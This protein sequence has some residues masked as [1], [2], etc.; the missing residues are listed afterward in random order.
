[1]QTS[2]LMFQSRLLD[3]QNLAIMSVEAIVQNCA[4]AIIGL[5]PHEPR[6]L[7]RYS[8]RCLAMLIAAQRLSEQGVAFWRYL[9]PCRTSGTSCVALLIRRAIHHLPLLMTTSLHRAILHGIN[10]SANVVDHFRFRLGCLAKHR[11]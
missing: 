1:M 11:T 8:I 10:L 5:L 3:G 6:A 9:A 2:D 4:E 7:T